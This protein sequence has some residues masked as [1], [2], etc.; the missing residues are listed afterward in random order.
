MINTF[1]E[2]NQRIKQELAALRQA[3]IR[4]EPDVMHDGRFDQ[5]FASPI[6]ILGVARELLQEMAQ[7]RRFKN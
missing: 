7:T 6:T 5:M 2:E 4:V 3:I 1:Q